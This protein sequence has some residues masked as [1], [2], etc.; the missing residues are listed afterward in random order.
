MVDNTPSK[1]ISALVG[2]RTVKHENW[3]IDEWASHDDQCKRCNCLSANMGNW[4]ACRRKHVWN[5]L[6]EVK[7]CLSWKHQASGFLFTP[8]WCWWRMAKWCTLILVYAPLSAEQKSLPKIVAQLIIKLLP[9]VIWRWSLWFFHLNRGKP[10]LDQS[11]KHSLGW[12][13]YLWSSSWPMT[14]MA[15][16]IL[17][18]ITIM[19]S[20]KMTMAIRLLRT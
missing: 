20:T 10:P 6:T 7:S 4:L 12:Q 8:G 16:I 13:S 18:I 14:M 5:Y 17:V 11:P 1:K 19:I 15:M 9:P 2:G 3:L